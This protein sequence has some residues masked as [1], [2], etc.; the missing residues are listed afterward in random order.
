MW[1]ISCTKS[2]NSRNF[3]AETFLTAMIRDVK[4]DDARAI[5]DIYRG[6][7]VDGVASFETRAVEEPEM[8]RRIAEISALYPY[9][10]YEESGHVVGY[11]YAHAWKERAAYCHTL[12]TTIYLA[13]DS[14]GKGIGRQLMERLIDD[15]RRRGFHAL[16]ACVTGGNEASCALHRKLGFK[17]VSMFEQVGEKFGQWLDVV[18]Y[19]LLL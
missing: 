1:P 18:D 11:C 2:E 8:R 3:A 9:F 13:P 10:V 17:Q 12:E 14:C 4:L 16:I 19:E 6:Y 15:C 7:V 5:A